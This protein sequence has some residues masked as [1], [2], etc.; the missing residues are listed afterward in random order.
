LRDFVDVLYSPG[1]ADPTTGYQAFIDPDSFVDQIIIN[2]L[3]REMDSYIRS[4]Y[5]HKDRAGKI[6]AGP[7]WDYNLSL[8]TGGFFEN[9]EIAGW[10]YEQEREPIA[11]AWMNRLL[12]DP[13]FV[14]RLSAR[15]QA[16][17]ADLLS[18]ASLLSRIDALTAPLQN[19]AGRNF[20]RW[21]N[22]T[23]PMVGPFHTPTAGTWQGQ[24]DVIRTWVVQRA[25]WI[26][27]QWQ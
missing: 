17:R 18:D 19:A 22:L 8:D 4:A 15:W 26:D 2:E 10:Q 25:A 21:P 9:R 1:F 14:A 6:F 11:N 23:E 7:I 3:G 13:A 5:F 27:T 16:L 20:A 12:E 24:V